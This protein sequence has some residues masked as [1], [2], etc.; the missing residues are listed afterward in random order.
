MRCENSEAERRVPATAIVAPTVP[1]SYSAGKQN[2]RRQLLEFF[3]FDRDYVRRLSEGDIETERHFVNYFSPL[4]HAKLR[5]RLRS[6]QEINDLR[7]EVFLRVLQTVRVGAGIQQPER[8]GAF[9]HS[10]CNNVLLEHFRQSGRTENWDNT[11]DVRQSGIDI[12][13]KL[14]IEES[15]GQVRTLL[16]ELPARDRQVLSAIFL[17]ERNK[18]VVCAEFGVSRDYL[19]VLL[20]RARLRFRQLIES[21][22]DR[23]ARATNA[24]RGSHP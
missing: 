24:S 13:Q 10:V 23:S 20:H 16:E 11:S 22:G 8:L 14:L 4:L 6:D 7:Q 3:S 18:D 1:F 5:H 15:R 19:R 9:V 12:E 17:E 2:N 21:A